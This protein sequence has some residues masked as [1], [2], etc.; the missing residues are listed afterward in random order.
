MNSSFQ[1]AMLLMH[2]CVVSGKRGL[3]SLNGEH[4]VAFDWNVFML[5]VQ[6]LHLNCKAQEKSNFLRFFEVG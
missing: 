6:I 1:L 2:K 4:S 5:S 3:S